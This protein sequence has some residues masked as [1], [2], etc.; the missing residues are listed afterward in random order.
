MFGLRLRILAT[1]CLAGCTTTVSMPVAPSTIPT[2]PVAA[3]PGSQTPVTSATP[4]AL[5]CDQAQD[6]A[7][8]LSDDNPCPGAT[9]TLR[10]SGL[11]AA[12]HYE[13]WQSG[14]VYTTPCSWHPRDV[15]GVKVGETDTDG[16]GRV[17]F[18]FRVADVPVTQVPPNHLANELNLWLVDPKDGRFIPVIGWDCTRPARLTGQL[19][20]EKGQVYARPVTVDA[21]FYGSQGSSRWLIDKRSQLTS[22]GHYTFDNVPAPAGIEMRVRE[23]DWLLS[24]ISYG[25]GDVVK[26]WG[27]RPFGSSIVLDVGAPASG[28]YV[29]PY[30]PAIPLWNPPPPPDPETLI[31]PSPD[32]GFPADCP[33]RFSAVPL[34][35]QGDNQWAYGAGDHVTLRVRKLPPDTPFRVWQ[36]DTMVGNKV[37]CVG[38]KNFNGVEIGQ[39][40]SDA[41]GKLVQ[42][43]SLVDIDHTF[44]AF[45][46]LLWLVWPDGVTMQPVAQWSNVLPTTVAGKLYGEDGQPYLRPARILLHATLADRIVDM[47]TMATGGTYQFEGVP[48][49]VDLELGVYDGTRRLARRSLNRNIVKLGWTQSTPRIPHQGQPIAVDFGGPGSTA[50][51]DG[52]R[53]PLA[54]DGQSMK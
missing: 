26:Q 15:G 6:Y 18:P 34:L 9:T 40:R 45:E 5:P 13:V 1:L 16:N 33:R 20:D 19:L 43:L 27:D 38:P 17:L 44:F 49:P 28:P 21:A 12:H 32:P 36:A 3:S 37:P 4:N 24:S 46:T 8:D 2:Q 23:G 11:P 25:P 48:A 10:A 7:A 51:A 54:A 42:P 39:A 22:D 52:M 35:G 50:D 31:V 41:Q 30:R 47:T 29:F 14:P 53:Y